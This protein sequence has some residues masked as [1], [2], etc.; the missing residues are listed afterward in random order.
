M[1]LTSVINNGI[2][3]FG[4][5]H[6]FRDQKVLELEKKKRGFKNPCYSEKGE[7][8]TT[9]EYRYVDA[10]GDVRTWKCMFRSNSNLSARDPKNGCDELRSS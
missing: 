6:C 1:S 10:E 7:V 2:E 4:T 3:T 9:E 8:W 5:I